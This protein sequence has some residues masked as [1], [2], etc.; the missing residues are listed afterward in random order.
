MPTP[1]A[2]VQSEQV[3]VPTPVEPAQPQPPPTVDAQ[4]ETGAV[5]AAEVI[6]P[7]NNGVV[8]ELPVVDAPS[9]H[10]SPAQ[11]W[12]PSSHAGTPPFAE[13]NDHG[14]G[15]DHTKDPL[16]T[17][18][19]T[20]EQ[21]MDVD[22][23]APPTDP[24]DD[25]A[26]VRKAT[27]EAYRERERTRKFLA[28][29]GRY[30]HTASDE[31][32]E[33]DAD[34]LAYPP[35]PSTSS[36]A[37][38]AMDDPP[39]L[40]SYAPDAAAGFL[41]TVNPGV[42]LSEDDV[43]FDEADYIRSRLPSPFVMTPTVEPTTP[44]PATPKPLL[45][46]S[47][48]LPPEPSAEASAEP[49]AAS[50]DEPPVRPERTPTPPLPIRT[51]SPV[52]TESSESIRSSSSPEPRFPQPE[53]FR[54]SLPPDPTTE[55]APPSPP[56]D[57]DMDEDGP[58]ET[59]PPAAAMVQTAPAINGG[60]AVK[61]SVTTAPPIIV[62]KVPTPAQTAHILPLSPSPADSADEF[63]PGFQFIQSMPLATPHHQHVSQPD[64]ARTPPFSPRPSQDPPL[65][66]PP[67]I[68]RASLS[69]AP[70]NVP[71][72]QS[73]SDKAADLCA[74]S[75]NGRAPSPPDDDRAPGLSSPLLH[76]D[77]R[78]PST[79]SQAPSPPDD[80]RAP[81]LSSH[82]LS[83]VE[84]SRPASV[85][86]PSTSADVQTLLSALPNTE[87]PAESRR[88]KL[89]IMTVSLSN[90]SGGA[91]AND[92]IELES[93][94]D[95]D[96]ETPV[97]EDME[98]PPSPQATPTTTRPRDLPSPPL[99]NSHSLFTP[100]TTPRSTVGL[101]SR[102]QAA[103]GVH[104]PSAAQ[105]P[106]PSSTVP[107]PTA[108]PSH[109]AQ[110]NDYMVA[111]GLSTIAS[112]TPSRA[113]MEDFSI[114]GPPSPP[115]RPP[116]LPEV[117]PPTT[118]GPRAVTQRPL[119][120]L[121]SMDD[122]IFEKAP[123][124]PVPHV[125]PVNGVKAS[126]PAVNGATEARAAAAA[127]QIMDVDMDGTGADFHSP[128]RI[129]E[130]RIAGVGNPV[131]RAP[132]VLGPS[133]SFSIPSTPSA[134]T[135]A[136]TSPF[137]SWV[138]VSRHKGPD[139]L[140]VP[141]STRRSRSPVLTVKHVP[142]QTR[143]RTPSPEPSPEAEVTP[144]SSVDPPV[145]ARPGPP[146]SQTAPEPPQLLHMRMRD[147]GITRRSRSPLFSINAKP[148]E[149]V[150]RRLSPVPA[151]PART[152]SL[153][154]NVVG[155][156]ALQVY[157]APEIDMRS[158]E[159]SLVVRLKDELRGELMADMREE[160]GQLKSEL[161]VQM[162]EDLLV[163]LKDDLFVQLKQDLL[164][165][166]KEELLVELKSNLLAQLKDE[167]LVGLQAEL[168]VALKDE[169][170]GQLTDELTMTLKNSLREHLRADLK[171]DMIV[172]LKD[173]FSTQLKDHLKVLLVQL[174]DAVNSQLR[175]DLV[176]QLKYFIAKLKAELISQLK[177]TLTVHLKD[178][179]ITQVKTAL[180]A[181]LR[182]GLGAQREQLNLDFERRRL[183][184]DQHPRSKSAKP[185]SP[186][187]PST[188]TPSRPPLP[189]SRPSSSFFFQARHPLHHL[190]LSTGADT[191]SGMDVDASTPPPPPTPPII[192]S[193]SKSNTG[194]G[195]D[196]PLPVKSQRKQS[197]F[198]SGYQAS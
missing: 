78:A 150:P 79:N 91:S 60:P 76:A 147:L 102:A 116:P 145:D 195:S 74:P 14:S 143:P 129:L 133:S 149:A 159:N 161:L 90:A 45:E 98:G 9:G 146:L 148:A 72:V 111:P 36:N 25:D 95:M 5:S 188:T 7:S 39:A 165:E 15:D 154:P 81:G 53:E 50:P 47:H 140:A 85:H 20:F 18:D 56:P 110:N 65:V 12:A 107:A 23:A 182:D 126:Q 59:Q 164:T 106:P 162:K 94:T 54:G 48:E 151:S 119:S 84:Q 118:N 71:D 46:S 152:S 177:D 43:E 92:A 75:T 123:E 158:L 178:G 63:P 86:P 168:L 166:L 176:I 156:S 185:G 175:D 180:T 93:E 134:G 44:K 88:I 70:R 26:A 192:L 191:N 49:S 167:L 10:A 196:T 27:I 24:E 105:A 127:S 172:E 101:T 57:S 68:L 114:F 40:A 169:L 122:V 124:Q 179:L 157:R 136:S 99:D 186:A 19:D 138:P 112:R 181:Q 8:A 113:S 137:P 67:P 13:L 96:I 109:V 142:P 41:D 173:H 104:G 103:N 64:I 174:K 189:T 61:H 183:F 160:L 97:D 52:P 87:S 190:V 37:I 80:D 115:S 132:I 184:L 73:S 77:L 197:W 194:N 30:N 38:A 171:D 100:E 42:S 170:K 62:V 198:A 131:Q 21:E 117:S 2:A 32:D 66:E 1:T 17:D 163:Q 144:L 135:T 128:I 108:T 58:N 121:R 187:T 22:H 55:E 69:P 153:D 125:L 29:L 141:A 139:A 3:V 82:S 83:F 28:S 11:D 31:D 34:F 6:P 35:S 16:Q 130:E 120:P 33:L 51:A 155:S 89:E 193:P 4:T